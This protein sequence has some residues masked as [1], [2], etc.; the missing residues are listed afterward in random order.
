MDRQGE[1]QFYFCT[2]KGHHA[3]RNYMDN[4]TSVTKRCT[5]QKYMDKQGERQLHVYFCTQI[6]H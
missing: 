3:E 4:Y 6:G 5:W 1:K 2:Q